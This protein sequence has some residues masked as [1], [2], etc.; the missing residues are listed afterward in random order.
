MGV[1]L[2]FAPYYHFRIMEKFNLPFKLLPPCLPL[3]TTHFKR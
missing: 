1:I 2:I 3:Q